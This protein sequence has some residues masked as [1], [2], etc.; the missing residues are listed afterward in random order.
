MNNTA[1]S[2]VLKI[3]NK[4]VKQYR[5]RKDETNTTL[6]KRRYI[7]Q[8]ADK[9]TKETITDIDNNFEDSY[10]ETNLNEDKN[11]RSYGFCNK[12]DTSKVI[13]VA[14][15]VFFPVGVGCFNIGYWVMYVRKESIW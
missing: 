3:D 10:I 7:D 8:N 6:W 15:R 4:G 5:L 9:F 2:D 11:W 14:A 1:P 12:Y 13:E